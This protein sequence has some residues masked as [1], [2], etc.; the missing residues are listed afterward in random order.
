[1]KKAAIV[2]I[3]TEITDGQILN[4][5][6]KWLS[7]KLVDLNIDVVLHLSS[8]D[9]PLLIKKILALA[10][11]ETDLLF[12][13]GGLGP[14][15]DDITRDV[16]SEF[17]DLPLEFDEDSWLDVKS[18]LEARN[19]VLRE[20]HRRQ[21]L[22]PRGATAYKNASGVAPGFYLKTNTAKHF[23]ILPGPPGEIESLW[24]DFI[25]LQLQN[26]FSSLQE[27]KLRTWLCLGAPESELAYLT[28]TFFANQ[29]FTKKLGYRLQ[30][31][32]VEI[33]LWH[34]PSPSALTKMEKFRQE[35]EEFY[36]AD[37]ILEIHTQIEKKLKA[38]PSLLI[39]D[40]CSS[41]LF[42]ER[43]TQALGPLS[44]TQ[45]RYGLRSP[46]APAPSQTEENCLK[47]ESVGD[48]WVVHWQTP[49]QKMEWKV[50]SPS[51]KK[52]KWREHYVVEKLILE[53]LKVL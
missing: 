7:Q 17:L 35:I 4:S 49:T 43:L 51:N 6:A 41:G 21:C 11:L 19:V 16:V 39:D 32:Y 5:N 48:Q 1:M 8:P 36:V 50:S 29:P 31:P 28:E 24:K 45:I 12:V 18:K 53:W 14:T 15:S 40:T 33:K 9:D 42:L 3:G 23:W 20:G 2:T 26:D 47:I 38:L 10:A 22:L 30:A 13:S 25:H 34:L 37:V 52:S 44:Q 46:Q 27:S